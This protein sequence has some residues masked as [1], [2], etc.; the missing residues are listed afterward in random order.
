MRPPAVEELDDLSMRMDG[1]GMGDCS[2]IIGHP[3]LAVN[4]LAAYVMFDL[5]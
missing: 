2:T 1:L 5:I 3:T 4:I